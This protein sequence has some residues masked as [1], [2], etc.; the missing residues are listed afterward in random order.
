MLNTVFS[1]KTNKI[2]FPSN[3]VSFYSRAEGENHKDV[4]FSFLG[5]V[6][7]RTA[8]KLLMRTLIDRYK[9]S[10]VI[11]RPV[12]ESRIQLVVQYGLQLIQ[13]LGL[14]ENKQVLRTNCWTVYRWNDALLRWNSSHYE[15][16]KVLRILPSQIWTPDIRLYNLADERLDE[17]REGGLLV[18]DDGSILWLQ[19]V[20]F[21]STCQVEITY[22]PFDTQV[23]MLEFGSLTY[24]KTQLELEWWIPDGSDQPMP[25]V[26]FSDYV[27]ANEWITDGEAEKHIRHEERKKQI[28]SVKRYRVRDNVVAGNQRHYPVLRFLIRLHRNPSFHMFILIVP[29]LLL[30]VLAL[31]VFWLPP[32]S[33]AKMML[34][35]NI[36]VAFFVLLLLLAKSMPTAL[37]NF[38][39]IG[40]FF[41][42]NMGMITI[43]TYLAT[44]VVNLF[45]SGKDGRPPPLWVRRLIVDGVGRILFLRQNIPLAER[46]EPTCIEVGVRRTKWSTI[47]T[48]QAA[49]KEDGTNE[50]ENQEDPNQPETAEEES[51]IRSRSS[52]ELVESIKSLEASVSTIEKTTRSV[53]EDVRCLD[54]R[55]EKAYSQA[56]VAME[57]R[58]LALVVDRVFFVAYVLTLCVALVVVVCNT[59]VV[60]MSK[61]LMNRNA[62]TSPN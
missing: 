33:S 13:I 18:Y 8:E 60:D 28:R 57:W 17:Y 43:S 37:R 27:P 20:L 58:T 19:Q 48:N 41:C 56:M 11:G 35:I 38:P 23:C 10:G 12:N 40:V 52:S 22:F 54:R 49:I 15:G 44:L 61:V 62:I 51:G 3:D 9:K 55:Q 16:I 25:F 29:C 39:L 46:D 45:Y 31:I 26:D 42:L 47:L 14:D 4:P 1:Q 24:D 36:F 2:Y 53:N 30:S 34:G 7:Q 50:E 6:E 59:E 32:D 21:K 5:F